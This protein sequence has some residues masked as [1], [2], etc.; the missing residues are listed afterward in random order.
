MRVIGRDRL[1][2]EKGIRYSDDHLKRL[3][4][5]GLFPQSFP[6]GPGKVAYDEAEIDAWLKAK[7]DSRSSVAA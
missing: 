1:E 5:K 7:A 3:E 2:A 4:K 6:L